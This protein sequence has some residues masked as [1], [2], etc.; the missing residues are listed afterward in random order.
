MSKQEIKE[1]YKQTEG[2]PQVK[3]KI[4]EHQQRLAR[5]RMMQ[6]VPESGCRHPKPHALCRCD[7]L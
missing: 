3:G 6:N 5:R 4:K 1:E 7:P 2:D